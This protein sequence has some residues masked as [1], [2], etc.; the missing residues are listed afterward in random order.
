MG[1]DGSPIPPDGE[2][3]RRGEE[4][5]RGGDEEA[6]NGGDGFSRDGR[7][8]RAGGQ[9]LEDGGRL[10]RLSGGGRPEGLEGDPPGRC[11]K[12]YGGR[13]IGCATAV[14]GV[15]KSLVLVVDGVPWG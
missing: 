10:G 1:S 8:V 11:G 4:A 14:G 6:A 15:G 3:Y 9:V 7:D 13:R 2:A 5:Q 12:I